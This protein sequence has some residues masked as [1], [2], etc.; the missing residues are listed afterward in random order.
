MN[1]IL[2][3]KYAVEIE[4]TGSITKA[5]ENLYMGQPNL[6]RAIRELE[7]SLGINIFMRS[8][9]GVVPTEQGRVFLNYARDIL[10]QIEEM[11]NL[12]STAVDSRQRFDI[13]VPRASYVSYAFTGF[14]KE[15]DL[16][17]DIS[18]NYRETNS[19]QA[20]KNVAEGVNNIALVRYQTVYESFF[21]KYLKER[22]LQSE[23]IWE[24][25]NLALMSEAH[26]LAWQGNITQADLDEYTEIVHGDVAVPILPT[27]DAR[28]AS[29]SEHKRRCIVIYERGSQFELL[30]RLPTTYMWVSPLPEDVLQCFDLAQKK[31][32]VPDNS[33]KD[34]L[35]C[36]E[37]YQLNRNEMLFLEKLRDTVEMVRVC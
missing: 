5:A 31:C 2:H 36:R 1:N 3:L 29:N 6:S 25:E 19:M 22:R 4:R 24:F 11:E 21:L 26:P 32:Y 9:K 13:S 15:M 7:D 17:R 20:I 8:S 28:T 35:I 37:G 34:V 33:Y 18:V 27:S 12:C 16:S 14:L 10:R 30:S 23:E